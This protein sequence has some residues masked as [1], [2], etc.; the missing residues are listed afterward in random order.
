MVRYPVA[1][2]RADLDQ[3]DPDGFHR[4][5]GAKDLDPWGLRILRGLYLLRHEEATERNRPAYR[6]AP[7]AMMLEIAK[8]KQTR[9][10][11]NRAQGFWRRYGKR[12][13]GIVHAEKDKPKLSKPRRNDTRGTPDSPETKALYENLRKWRRGA[14]EDR[15]VEPWVV[16]RNELLLTIARAAPESDGALAEILEPFRHREYGAAM[17]EAIS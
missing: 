6:I 1:M 5:K 9:G 13:A 2:Q 16:V 17:L 15:G 4:I 11:N 3:F 12:V 7:D 14:A 10:E 8:R